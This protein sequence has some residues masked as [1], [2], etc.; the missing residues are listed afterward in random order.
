MRGEMIVLKLTDLQVRALKHYVECNA[1]AFDDAHG[2]LDRKKALVKSVV[3]EW[4]KRSLS[5]LTYPA[6]KGQRISFKVH[7]AIVMS[8][9]SPTT[10][11]LPWCVIWEL[12]TEVDKKYGGAVK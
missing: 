2:K 8:D 10:G 1:V 7:E 4:Y 12:R 5:A 11:T 9:M 6:R 3:T